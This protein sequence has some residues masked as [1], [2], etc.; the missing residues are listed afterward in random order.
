MP[1]RK[2]VKD[3]PREKGRRCAFPLPSTGR[4]TKGEGWLVFPAWL[5]N[6]TASLTTPHP[7]C[8]HL[9]PVEGRRLARGALNYGGSFWIHASNRRTA[10]SS[11]VM[12]E[13][14]G[15]RPKPRCDNRR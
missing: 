4:G 9:L 6:G 8:G 5:A 14:G 12:M 1:G 15:M 11:T 7:A 3:Y 2:A 10:S 13:R